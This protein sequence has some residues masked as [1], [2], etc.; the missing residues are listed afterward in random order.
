MWVSGGG[1]QLAIP[2]PAARHEA[3]DGSE[4]SGVLEHNTGLSTHS[5]HL[6]LGRPIPRAFGFQLAPSKV[7]FRKYS[8]RVYLDPHQNG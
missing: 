4:P 2:V 6:R 5:V 1:L 8:A 7:G 3:L